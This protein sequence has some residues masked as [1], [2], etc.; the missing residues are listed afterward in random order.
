MHPNLIATRVED[1]RM[2]S[3]CGAVTEQPYHPSR[4]C[5]ARLVGHR[6]AS[7]PPRIAV[8]RSVGRRTRVQAWAFA[9]APSTLHIVSKGG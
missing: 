5:L 7:C 4:M 1:R 8:L 2:S 6:H 3:R 9:V